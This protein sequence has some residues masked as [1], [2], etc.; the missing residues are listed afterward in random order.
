MTTTNLKIAT[1]EE[2]PLAQQKK[3]LRRFM[4]ERRA[5]NENR[6]VKELLM[7]ENL[8]STLGVFSQK[9]EEKSAREGVKS[10]KE[11]AKSESRV[12]FCYLSFSSEA[13]TDKLIERLKEQ[14]FL[15]CCP[16]V[17]NGEM[18]AVELSEDYTISFLGIREPIGQAYTGQ[19]DYV[20]TPL[21]AVDEQG[22]RLGY[23][24]GFYDRFFKANPQAKRIGYAFDFQIIKQVPTEAQDEKL[25]CIVTE[26]RTLF[27]KQ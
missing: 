18:V 1:K 17:E 26:K 11:E 22:N 20:I 5:N 24:G 8:L 21:L 4:K 25:D 3:N 2:L 16:R 6:D 27:I 7:I 23:G 9:E 10:A 13:P 19:I 14:G 15:V 12:C